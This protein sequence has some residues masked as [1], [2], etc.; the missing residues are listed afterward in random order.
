M[1]KKSSAVRKAIKTG[2][3]NAVKKQTARTVVKLSNKRLNEMLSQAREHQWAGQH[4]KAIEVCTQALDAIGQGNSRT[5]QIQMDLLGIRAESHIARINMDGLQKDAKVMMQIA[6]AAPSSSKRKKL[7]LKAQT[8]IFKGLVF[9]MVESNFALARIT[10]SNAVETARQSKDKRLEAKSLYFLGYYQTGEQAIKTNQQAVDQFRSNDDQHGL[11]RA[12]VNLA[13]AKAGAGHLE[14]ARQ[15]AQIALE[16]SEQIGYNLGKGQALRSLAFLQTDVH[17]AIL[18]DKQALQA[19][20]ASGSLGGFGSVTNNLGYHYSLLGL[21]PRSV[22]YYQKGIEILPLYA[23]ALQRANIIHIEIEQGALDRANEHIIELRSME[24]GDGLKAFT[25][26]LAGRVAMLE[27]NPQKAVRHINKAIRLSRNAGQITEIGELALL[28]EAYLADGNLNAALKSSLRAVKKHRELNFPSIDDHPS[29][30]IWWRHSLALRANK[31][32]KEADEAL[33]MAYGF[34]LKG[35]ESLHDDGLRRNYLNKVR[36]NREIL[37]AWA[38]KSQKR[39]GDSRVAPTMPH[40]EVE[41]SLREPFER[42]AEISL[43]LNALKSIKEIQTFL[44]EEATELIGGER[45]FLI[46][47]KDEE[48]ELAESYVPIGEDTQQ[49][50]ASIKKHLSPARRTRTVQLIRPKRKGLSRIVA[51]LIAQNQVIGYLYVDMDSLYGAFDETDR[52]MLGMQANHGAV[53]LDNAGLLEELERKVE[54][55]TADLSQSNKVQKALFKIADAASASRDMQDFYEKVHH[56][57]GELMYAENFFIAQYEEATKMVSWSYYVDSVDENP[58]EPRV[59]DDGPVSRSGTVYVIRHGIPLHA[60]RQDTLELVKQ[61][62]LETEGP[63]DEDWI[64]IPLKSGKQTIGVLVIQS[65]LKDVRYTDDDF[66]L[67]IFVAQHISTAM[68]RARALE[69]ERQ[70]TAE[71]AILNSVQTA[72][73]SKLDF[74][75]IVDSVGDKLAEIFSVENVGIGFLDK[76]SGIMKVPYLFENGKRIE[77]LEF[78]ISEWGFVATVVETRKPLMINSNIEQHPERP[79]PKSWLGVPIIIKDEVVGGFTIQNWERENAFNDSDVRLLQTLAGSLGVAL[80]NAR[81]FE[82]EQQRVAELQIINSVQE[83]LAK[84]LD[85]QKIID[86]VGDKLR[87]IFN[88]DTT[89]V[90]M[91]DIERDWLLNVYYVDRGERIPIPDGPIQRPS[92]TAIGVDTCKPLLFHTQEEMIKQGAVQTPSPGEKVDRNQSFLGVPILTGNKLIGLIAVQSYKQYAYKQDDLRLLQTLANSMS[93][94]LENARLFDETQRLFK[95]EQERVAELQIINS[96]Q[97]GLAAELDFQAIV[98]LVGDKL[99]E[100]FK[101][102]DLGIDWYDEE[103]KLVHFL[104]S[105]EHGKRLS[106]PSLPLGPGK[107]HEALSQ[108][109]QPIIFKN[110]G[111][112]AAMNYLALPGTDQSKSG[113]VVP[114]ISGDRVLGA[115]SIE[116]FKREDAFGESEVRLLTTIAASLGTALENARLFDET[117]QRNAELAVINAV[118]GAL[119][120]ELDIQEIYDV[121]GEKLREIFDFQTVTIYSH[122]LESNAI[123]MNYG[124]EK[125]QKYPPMDV[126]LNSLYEHILNLDSTFVRNGDFPEFAVNFKDWKP[127]QGEIPQSVLVTPVIRKKD[128]DN[129]VVIALMDIDSGKTFS[130]TDIRLVETVAN[131]MSVALEN[132]RLFDEVQKKNTEIT[133]S[134]ERETAS[135]DILRVIAESPTDI[136]PVLDVIARN[137]AQLSGSEDALISLR[138]GNILRVDAHYGDIPMIPVGEGIRFDRDS[139]AGRAILEGR[140]VQAVH[141]QRGAK[142]KFPAGDKVAKKYGYKMTCAVPLMREGKAIGCI[143]IRRAQPELLTD[144]QI[145]LVQSFANQAAIAVENVRLFEAEQQRVAELQI[146]NTVQ[147]GLARQLDFRGIVDLIGEKVGEIF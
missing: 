105:Y 85:F 108:K 121:V 122:A 116:D 88:A 141:N 134:L 58:P 135:N 127:S 2:K 21:Y 69:A 5:A 74:Q 43:E 106:L 46:L 68:T 107:M 45:V 142:S 123:H 95:A 16:M 28:G 22:R 125:G 84:Q 83:G 77:N 80:E 70:R 62:V 86:L 50:L 7:A 82:A 87:E 118:Q 97:Q 145:A 60:T 14:E 93:V 104:Y 100:V 143:S 65:Y 31:K 128:S 138:D 44:V 51:P 33:E 78:P 79:N 117:Q 29:Q 23:T 42:L 3:S 72:L 115:I 133:E 49:T 24:M 89:G 27:G 119:A 103:A 26:E 61:G 75:G 129:V 55:R 126:P 139:V 25:E 6:N 130:D 112:M 53:A 39:R 15:H 1:A 8:L 67:L 101:T 48:L 76:A 34:L 18:S 140:T 110:I 52:D 71:L 20:E 98:D 37:Q 38:K 40:L 96:I 137:A 54:E 41:S 35:I 132:A 17:Q 111:E 47:E 144:K 66:K 124:F 13:Y 92:L 4:E 64:G 56:V 63:M 120:A 147:E 11:I 91:V 99:R 146:I 136:A 73:A 94:A 90:G 10:L 109:R 81:L 59:I 32:N 131:A 12:L 9:A 102:G 57:V 114:I 113:I 30:N 19:T 36:I